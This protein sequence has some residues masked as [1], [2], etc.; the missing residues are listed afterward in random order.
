MCIRH[1][2]VVLTGRVMGEKVHGLQTMVE[3]LLSFY[4]RKHM[5]NGYSCFDL[6]LNKSASKSNHKINH[7]LS[8][9]VKFMHY[10]YLAFIY[11]HHISKSCFCLI[12]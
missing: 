11:I 10:T 2:A 3:T 5:Y 9:V 6:F 8:N 1:D 4:S 7:L 12:M